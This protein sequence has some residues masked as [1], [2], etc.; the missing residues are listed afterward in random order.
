MNISLGARMSD[1]P[2]MQIGYHRSLTGRYN[3]HMIFY[4]DP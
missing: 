3:A 4:D 2:A 1:A